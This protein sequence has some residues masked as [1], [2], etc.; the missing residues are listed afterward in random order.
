MGMDGN[1]PCD[2]ERIRQPWLVSAKAQGPGGAMDKS[3]S[4]FGKVAS[5]I[6]FPCML[7]GTSAGGCGTWSLLQAHL[8]SKAS[9]AQEC[10]N[11]LC[12]WVNAGTPSSEGSL[13][14]LDVPLQSLNEKKV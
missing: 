11:L 6:C 3:G 2:V 13:S 14:T 12:S 9:L 5:Q 4:S 1:K 7:H 10:Q 8:P